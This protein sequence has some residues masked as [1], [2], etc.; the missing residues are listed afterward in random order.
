MKIDNPLKNELRKKTER[1]GEIFRISFLILLISV[2]VLWVLRESVTLLPL[3]RLLVTTMIFGV[4]A[5]VLPKGSIRLE[6]SNSSGQLSDTIS[7]IFGS[8]IAVAATAGVITLTQELR[9]GLVIGPL[10]GIVVALT[11]SAYL[12]RM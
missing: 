10:T 2:L 1:T 9:F 8:I 5:T 12:R 7:I 6:E 4:I 3:E 11:T